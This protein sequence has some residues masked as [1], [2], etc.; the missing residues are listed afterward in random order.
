MDRVRIIIPALLLLF[1]GAAKAQEDISAPIVVREPVV[2]PDNQNGVFN[3]VDSMPE[4]PGGQEAL[5]EYLSKN[6]KYPEAA[7]EAGI[8]GAVYVSF[9]VDADGAIRDALVMRG[10][11]GGCDEEALRVVNSMPL[12]EPGMQRGEA[13]MVK[14]RMP[15]R[16]RLRDEQLEG[17]KKK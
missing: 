12:W 5:V 9:T 11:G 6:I 7:I 3:F 15:I 10:I 4:F 16:F 13:V 17:G 14:Y 1:A 2:E 8:Q